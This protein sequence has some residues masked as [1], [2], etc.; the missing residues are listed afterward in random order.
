MDKLPKFLI[1]TATRGSWFIWISSRYAKNRNSRNKKWAIA[2]DTLIGTIRNFVGVYSGR[3]GADEFKAQL[4]IVWK[5]K[6]L[7]EILQAKTAWESTL[8]DWE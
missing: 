8:P 3:I 4:G 2:P 1:D 7:K 6:A 5:I